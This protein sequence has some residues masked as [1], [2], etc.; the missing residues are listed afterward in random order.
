MRKSQ[1]N[2]NK[3]KNKKQQLNGCHLNSRDKNM[4]DRYVET[5]NSTT[6]LPYS[7]LYIHNQYD[8]YDDLK[9][10]DKHDPYDYDDYNVN[11]C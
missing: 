8:H 6:T 1:I 10:Y 7:D 3:N 11:D 9:I 5:L 4:Q 2:K